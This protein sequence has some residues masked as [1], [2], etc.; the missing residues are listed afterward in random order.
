M[1]KI[2]FYLVPNR[3]VVTTDRTGF[4]T[5]FRQV[6][7]RKLK[8]Y[9]GIDNAIQI[10]VR[11]SEQR[12]QDVAG[13]TA[14]VKFFDAARKELFTAAATPIIGQPG[15]MEM[16][17]ASTDIAKI[18]PQQLM[19]A[20]FITESTVDSP[21]YI[22]GQFGLFGNVE[23]LDGFNPAPNVTD[24]LNVFNFEFDA[25]AYFSEMGKFGTSL[26]EDTATSP[27]KS[28][29]VEIYPNAGFN[30]DVIAYVTNDMSTANS[31]AWKQSTTFSIDAST[32]DP[33]TN[34]F[35]IT[36]EY[37]FIRFKFKKYIETT[38]PFFT[39]TGTLDK[40]IIRN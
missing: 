8:I 36:G 11:N 30:G 18:D 14:T 40:I 29:T 16:T 25:M 7:Q 2:Q 10:D 20:A 37:R 4:N 32:H 27:V 28:V 13:T 6:Y 31:V 12:K 22:D 24:T 26:N 19:M 35:S 1:Q 38:E 17:I 21:L 15:Q 33:A 34:T 39:L 3:I 23:L 5:E 9:K